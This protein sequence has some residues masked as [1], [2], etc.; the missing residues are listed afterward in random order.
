MKTHRSAGSF[1]ENSEQ[2]ICPVADM[3]VKLAGRDQVFRTSASIQ[4][5]LARGEEHNDVLQGESNGSQLS[6]QRTDD[7]EVRHDFLGISWNF[8]HRHH[9]ETRVKTYTY[10]IACIV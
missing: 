3:S 7:A 6:D 10:D 4:E 9:V 2:F 5:H 1:A 8:V